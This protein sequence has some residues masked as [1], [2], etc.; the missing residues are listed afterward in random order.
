MVELV[1][2]V[3]EVPRQVQVGLREPVEVAEGEHPRQE[4]G[5]VVH[6][7]SEVVS[8]RGAESCCECHVVWTRVL[9]EFGNDFICSSLVPLSHPVQ[10]W[11]HT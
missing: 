11:N 6:G 3:C 10:I 8:I 1:A 7:R 4:T 2:G 5:K 9:D